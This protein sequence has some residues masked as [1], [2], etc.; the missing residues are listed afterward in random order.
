[1]RVRV[2]WIFFST[3]VINTRLAVIWGVSG[4]PK[5]QNIPAWGT[6]PGHRSVPNI[7]FIEFDA[8]L[9]QKGPVFFLERPR[10]VMLL[11]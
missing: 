7:A 5:A 11:L 1:M 9:G 2:D 10:S 3:R 4:G 6:A 8:V